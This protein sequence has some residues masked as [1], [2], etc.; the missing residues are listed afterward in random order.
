M[1]VDNFC[2]ALMFSIEGI[3]YRAPSKAIA[4]VKQ[5]AWFTVTAE[6]L[7]GVGI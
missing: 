2:E 5:A 6:P 7:I 3:V 4:A 1:E